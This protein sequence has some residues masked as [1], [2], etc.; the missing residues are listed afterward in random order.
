MIRVETAAVDDESCDSASG[1][2]VDDSTV[3]DS[4]LTW[5]PTSRPT[6]SYHSR[7]FLGHQHHTH[8]TTDTIKTIN[9]S[10]GPV[11]NGRPKILMSLP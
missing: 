10:Q 6:W 8:R 9:V 11:C 5:P 2:S 1:D 7:S 3:T 4:A